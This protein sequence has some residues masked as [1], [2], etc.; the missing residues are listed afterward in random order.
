MEATTFVTLQCLLVQ[1]YGSLNMS[2]CSHSP[3]SNSLLCFKMPNPLSIFLAQLRFYFG[4]DFTMLTKCISIR[5][6]L[7]CTAGVD[8]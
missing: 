5:K 2:S 1:N 6:I 3:D 4:T 8:H 7:F